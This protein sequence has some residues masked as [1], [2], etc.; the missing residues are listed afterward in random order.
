MTYEP[1]Q[2]EQY[3]TRAELARIIGVHVNTIDRLVKEGMPSETWGMRARRF[4]PSQALAWL[5]SREAAEHGS[6]AA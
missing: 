5:R 4:L 6:V 3:V 1:Q 2:I